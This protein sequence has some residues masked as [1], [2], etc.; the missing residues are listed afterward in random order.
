MDL[1]PEWQ[2]VHT[3]F[4]CFT[5]ESVIIGNKSRTVKVDIFMSLECELSVIACYKHSIGL[6]VYAEFH[7]VTAFKLE[8]EI[9]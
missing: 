3:C 6:S 9:I 2:Q 4:I 8:G 5:S 7:S 1:L